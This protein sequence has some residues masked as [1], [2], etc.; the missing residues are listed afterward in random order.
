[1]TWE[2]SSNSGFSSCLKSGRPWKERMTKKRMTRPTKAKAASQSRLVYLSKEDFD[3]VIVQRSER[4][5]HQTKRFTGNLSLLAILKQAS[6]PG[7]STPN[8]RSQFRLAS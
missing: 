2:A 5:A 8:H 7:R 3:W 4:V 1:M 6:G